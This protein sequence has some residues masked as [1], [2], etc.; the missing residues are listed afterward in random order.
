MLRKITFL[1]IAIC[2]F[3]IESFAQFQ[4]LKSDEPIE[5]LSDKVEYLRSQDKAKF[6]GNVIATQGDLKLQC[7][8]MIVFFEEGG[9][10]TEKSNTESNSIRL[11]ELKDDV[12]INNLED[13][14]RAKW[15]QYKV[16]ED[17]FELKGDVML[18]QKDDVM[19]GDHLIYRRK[20]QEAV[21]NS[22]GKANR[23]RG[24]FKARGEQN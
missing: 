15:G 13:E 18:K 14:A 7:L 4:E 21:L 16:Q 9:I 17:I 6:K 22:S 10:K 1:S 12:M 23:V 20:T 24:I 2:L 11:I 8:E 19:Y 3:A 5:I